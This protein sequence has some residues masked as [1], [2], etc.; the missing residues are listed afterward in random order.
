MKNIKKLK[1][2]NP[3]YANLGDRGMN[4]DLGDHPAVPHPAVPHPAVP[5]PAV[6]HPAVPRLNRHGGM[7]RIALGIRL[8]PYSRG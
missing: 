6:P 5:H 3:L 8:S 7:S 1:A 4:P 2:K